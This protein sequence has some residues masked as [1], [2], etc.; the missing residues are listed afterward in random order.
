MKNILFNKFFIVFVSILIVSGGV[1]AFFIFDYNKTVDYQVVGAKG[2][3][4]VTVDLTDQILN[5]S[6]NLTSTQDLT[7]LNQN[8]AANFNYTFTKNL[9]FVESGCDA[10]GDISFE[11]ESSVGV[12]NN[13]GNFTMNPGFNNFNFIARA[14]NNRV[15]PQNITVTL[16]FV[17]V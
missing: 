1:L 13:G 5:V 6:E 2:N 14:V 8:G 17:E 12:I 3:L 9:T 11:L 10:T 16:D 7:I 4:T 15:C